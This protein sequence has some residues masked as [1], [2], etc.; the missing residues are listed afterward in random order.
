LIPVLFKLSISGKENFPRRGPLLVVGNH[1]AAM[2][3]VL[4][5]VFSP[6]Q[7]EML[8]AADM[9]AERI[10]EM[11]ADLYGVIPIHRGAY[12]RAALCSYREGSLACFPRAGSG[13]KAGKKPF[14]ESPG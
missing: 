14:R 12:D 13:K 5:A 1:T 7:I 3:A 4:M 8:S 6:W 9:P 2:E 10:T 11:V